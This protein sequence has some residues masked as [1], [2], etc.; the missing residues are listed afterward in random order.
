MMIAAPLLDPTL[1]ILDVG[2]GNCAV[3]EHGERTVVLD[4]GPKTGLLEYL[5]SRGV[6]T[7]DVVLISHD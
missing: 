7:L 5:T 6:H 4:C 2:H 1:T 3:L